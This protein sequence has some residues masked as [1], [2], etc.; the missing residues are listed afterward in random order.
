MAQNA[1]SRKERKGYSAVNYS[2]YGYLFVAPFFIAFAVF[3]LYSLFFTFRISFTDLTN[4]N[5]K[6]INGVGFANYKRMFDPNDILCINFWIAFKNTCIIWLVNFVPQ[7]GLALILACWFTNTQLRIKGKGAFKMMMFMPNI[8]TAATLAILFYSLFNYP[9]APVNTLLQQIGLLNTPYEFYRSTTASRSLI[10][11]IQFWMWYGNTMIILIAG[12]LGINPALFEAAMLDGCNGRQTFTK[13]TLPL[14]KPILLY[15]LVTSL[16]GGL[17]MFDIPYLLTRGNPNGTT[18]TV[19]RFIYLQAF[20]G[21]F[22]YNIAS[23][24]S[25]V[26]FGVILVLSGILFW[27]MRDRDTGV[28]RKA[29]R[30]AVK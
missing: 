15:N 4:L 11:F 1:V 8:I 16:I 10:S 2:R 29:K 22:N 30:R 5:F 26:L 9:I 7:I 14:L 21:S 17:Q 28:E 19:A 25:V 27:I 13:I 12:I 20:E 23:T 18:D 6:A 24:A 3:T